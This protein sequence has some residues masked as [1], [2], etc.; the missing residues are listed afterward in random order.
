[1]YS[2]MIKPKVEKIFSELRTEVHKIVVEVNSANEAVNRISQRVSSEMASRSKTILSD[3]LFD[4]NDTLLQTPFFADTARQNKFAEL[5]LRQEILSKYQFT[6]SITVNYKKA[7]R[8]V[9][10]LK[11]GGGTLVIGGIGEIGVVLIAGLSLSSLVPVP[12]GALVA[13]AFGAAMVD[14]LAIEPN[15]S[16]KNFFQ[17]IDKYL[18]EAQQQFLTWFD[19]VE[20][21]FNQR[22]EG[23][24]QTI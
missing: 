9:Q 22:V 3:M 21:Y 16:K 11:V 24:K 2:E 15:R 5:N 1:M 8:I 4:L 12:V 6:V 18:S 20:N 13:V 7:S 17:A 10:A 19:E 14:Y 23:I